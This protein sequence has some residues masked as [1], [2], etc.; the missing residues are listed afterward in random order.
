VTAAELVLSSAVVPAACADM[1]DVQR[2]GVD[3]GDRTT[4]LGLR[5]H[6]VRGA[7]AG[8]EYTQRPRGCGVVAYALMRGGGETLAVPRG[9]R[10]DTGKGELGPALALR[11]CKGRRWQA[12][13]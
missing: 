11:S 5:L 9:E 12:C 3:R 10:A 2:S 4:S 8:W 1:K 7:L 6:A 13:N